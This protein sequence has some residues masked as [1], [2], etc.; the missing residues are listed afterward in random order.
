[1]NSDMAGKQI[2]GKI[3]V[4]EDPFCKQAIG[5]RPRFPANMLMFSL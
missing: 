3:G 5:D 2:G 1:M 4:I